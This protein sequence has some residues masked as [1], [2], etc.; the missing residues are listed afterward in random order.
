MPK[1]IPTKAEMAL[2]L[3]QIKKGDTSGASRFLRG[4]VYTQAVALGKPE[5]EARALAENT[6]LESAKIEVEFQ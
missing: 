1:L 6:L 3:A 2:L 4:C 5:G